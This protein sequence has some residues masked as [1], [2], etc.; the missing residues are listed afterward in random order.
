MTD[1]HD[2]VLRGYLD[3]LLE[4]SPPPVPTDATANMWRLCTLGRLQLLLPDT[5]LGKAVACASVAQAPADWHLAR[6]PIDGADWHAAELVRCIAPDHAAPPV[7][8]LMPITG[9]RWMLAIPGHPE[10]LA[11]PADAIQ[12]RPHRTSRA[13]LAGMSRDGRY[14]ALDVHTLVAQL[15][16]TVGAGMEEPSP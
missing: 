4:A 9:S 11:L 15:A 16:E 12:W 7:E 1:A 6:L 3:A 2:G 10:L 8:T 14:M 13:W 5:A